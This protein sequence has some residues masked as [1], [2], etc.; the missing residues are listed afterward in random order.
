MGGLEAG[1]LAAVLVAPLWSAQASLT[2]MPCLGGAQVG[3]SL[4]H[5]L[6][7]R[8]ALTRWAG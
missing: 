5:C 6:R 3:L 8:T 1:P 7:A 2:G 4:T